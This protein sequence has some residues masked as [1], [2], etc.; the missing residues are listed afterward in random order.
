MLAFTKRCIADQNLPPSKVVQTAKVEP[1]AFKS[2][3]G[4]GRAAVHVIVRAPPT[5]NP[6]SIC[7]RVVPAMGVITHKK[8]TRGSGRALLGRTGSVETL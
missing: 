6:A 3:T 1:L 5:Q 2:L 7:H 4:K 8:D